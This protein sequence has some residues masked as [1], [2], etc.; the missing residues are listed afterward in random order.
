MKKKICFIITKS[1]IGGAQKWL[2]E[3]VNILANEFEIY[4]VTNKEGWLTNEMSIE[5]MLLD[6]NIE[7]KLSILFLLKLLKFIRINKINLIVASSANA[8]IYS[9]LVKLFYNIKVVYVS[10]GWSA[11]YNGGFFSFLYQKI[12]CL[13]SF[14]TDSILCISSSDYKKAHDILKINKKKTRLIPNK[15][16]PVEYNL[17]SRNRNCFNI[18]SVARLVHPKRLDLL[19]DSVRDLECRL[20][21]VGDGPLKDNLMKKCK[22]EGIENVTFYGEILNFNRFNEFDAFALISDSEGLAISALESMSVGL[23]L[24][25]SNVGGCKELIDDNG[26]LVDNNVASIRDG[27]ID[28][29]NNYEKYG[30]NSLRLFNQKYNLLKNYTEYI[31]YYDEL[32]H[33]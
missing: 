22:N 2:R 16:M 11:I 25:L 13:L 27:I 15:I 7:K 24:V 33:D 18:L 3:Q 9:R 8:G 23:P 26:V 12:E 17:I 4:L 21:I 30:Y 32:M 29:V 31:N 5:D 20:H 28:V 6:K 1:E 10:H 19:I 14:I